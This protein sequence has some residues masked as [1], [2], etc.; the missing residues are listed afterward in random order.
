MDKLAHLI[1]PR[2]SNNYKSK[3]IHNHILFLFIL[4]FL[5]ATVFTTQVKRNFPQVL[6]TSVN[7]T[8]EQ[9]LKEVNNQRRINNLPL[10]S[11]NSQLSN[12]AAA[13][14]DD[15]FNNNYWAHISPNGTTPWY[16]IKNSGY[17]YIYAGENLARGFASASDTVAAWMDSPEHRENQLSSSYQDVGFAVKNG[18]LLG[19]ET[20][21]I[22]EE[23]GGKNIAQI[24]GQSDVGA[25]SSPS[26]S[27]VLKATA[28]PFIDIRSFSSNIYL[29]I[30]VMFIVIL[31]ID[32]YVVGKQKIVRI[33]GH[34]MDHILFFTTM[35][36]ASFLLIKGVVL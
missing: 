16:F 24:A 15:M 30:L 9:L 29:A 13:K 33:S 26:V 23:F 5:W 21:L 32:M 25:V 1:F 19:E 11:L 27:S 4:F 14:A 7:I 6:G 35:I 18:I 20:T 28:S 22:V 2:K 34:N 31:S 17:S 3:L 36:L 12:A 8:H 10:F